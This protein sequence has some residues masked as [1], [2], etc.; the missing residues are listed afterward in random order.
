M[1][2]KEKSREELLAELNELKSENRALRNSLKESN[3]SSE[4]TEKETL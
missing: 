2:R 1:N 4:V 3:I